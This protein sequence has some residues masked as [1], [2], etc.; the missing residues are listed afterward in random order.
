MALLCTCFMCVGVCGV[1]GREKGRV[2][3]GSVSVIEKS[4]W[5]FLFC[6]WSFMMVWGGC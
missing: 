6:F 5:M 2:S 4:E 3:E 1:F